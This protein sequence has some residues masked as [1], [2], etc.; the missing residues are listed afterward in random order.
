[1]LKPGRGNLDYRHLTL[2]TGVISQT[3]GS[4]RLKLQ[5]TDVIVG[6]KFETGTPHEDAPKQGMIQCSVEW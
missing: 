6:I 4:A 1:M 3:N 2:E 5:T